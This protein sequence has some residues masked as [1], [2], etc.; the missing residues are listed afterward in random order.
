[1]TVKELI[2]KLQEM[3]QDKKVYCQYNDVSITAVEE[4][5]EIVGFDCVEEWPRWYCNV[6]AALNESGLLH[7]NPKTKLWNTGKRF[8]AYRMTLLEMPVTK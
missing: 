8:Q 5:A 7:Y 4:E 2:K 1:M 6:F 3:P